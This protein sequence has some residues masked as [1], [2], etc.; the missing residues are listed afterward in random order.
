MNYKKQHLFWG[1][2]SPLGGLTGFGLL[3]MASSR[4]SWALIVSGCIFWVYTLCCLSVTLLSTKKYKILP[5]EGRASLFTCMAYF[6]GRIYLL[7]LWLFFPLAA[8]E[9]FLPVMLVPLFCIGSG[10]FSRMSFLNQPEGN[11]SLDLAANVYDAAREA[12]VLA[13][14]M[15]I[16]SLIRE[17]LSYNTLSVPGTYMGIVSLISFTSESSFQIRIISNSASALLLLGYATGLYRYF[18]SIYAP[19]E[20]DQ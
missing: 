5:Q 6:I 10:F 13:L 8:I 14:L 19:L 2:L 15:I 3:V 18:R 17:P 4:L 16:I 11:I 1:A 12:A 9:V 20:G 7:L